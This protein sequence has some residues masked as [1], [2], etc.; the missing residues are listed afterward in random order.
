MDKYT[1]TLSPEI[2]SAIDKITEHLKTDEMESYLEE[3]TV[4]YSGIGDSSLYGGKHCGSDAEHQ[5]AQYIYD[6][7]K[8]IGIKAEMLPFESAR[9]QFN[10][11]SI[12]IEGEE[13]VKP[14]VCLSI[15]T[16]KD[17][18]TG[19]LIDAGKGYKAFYE[20]NDV[21][22]KIVLIETKEDFEDGTTE[23]MFQMMEAQR[24]GAAAVVIYTNENIYDE[25]TIR[26]TYGIFKPE[27]PVV[28]V[29]YK[30][31]KTLKNHA[32]EPVV[33]IADAEFDKDGGTSYEV[34][35]EIPGRTDERIIY[36]A[37]YDHFF[38]GIQDNV[39][40]AGTLLAIA[41]ALKKSGYTPNRTITFVFSGSHEIGNMESGA[42]DLLGV[43]ELLNNLKKEWK[44]KIFADINFEYTALKLN[45]LRSLVS[46]EMT[47]MYSDFLR[48][49]PKEVEVFSSVESEIQAEEYMLLTWCDACPF[50][51]EG[52]P[53][54]M[55]DAAYEQIYEN[56]SSYIGRDHTNKDDMSIYSK[57]THL[58]ASW[59]YGCL[60]V[61]LDNMPVLMPDFSV[62]AQVMRLADEEKTLLEKENLDYSAFEKE[63]KSFELLGDVAAKLLKNFN[64]K[65]KRDFSKD[66]KINKALLEIQKNLADASDGLTTMLPP[67]L[68][69]PHKTYI[70][71]AAV[72][73]R[74]LA[75]F[76]TSGFEKTYEQELKKL[77]LVGLDKKFS[78]EIII[79]VKGIALGKNATWNKNKCKNFFIAEDVSEKNWQAAREQNLDDVR[80]TLQEEAEFLSKANDLLTDV[81][82]ET[83]DMPDSDLMMKKIKEM[84]VLPHRKTGT[85]E[86]KKSAEYVEKTFRET[87]LEEVQTE[88]I[89]SVCMEW[90]K[91]SFEYGG[92]QI[93]CF[94]ANGTN[95]KAET[96]HF[97]SNIENAEIIYLNTGSAEDFENID[98]KG[99]IVLCD[100]FFKPFSLKDMMN[101]V[102]DSEI[103]DPL[104]KAEKPLKKYDIYTPNN[105]PYNYIAAMEKGAAGFI[106]I[107]H[108]FMDCHYY[109][110]DYRDIVSIA[111]Y[112]ELPAVWL[113]KEDGEA[114]KAEAGKNTVLGSL[115]VETVYEKKKARC[116]KGEIKGKTNNYILIHSHHDAVNKG[117]VQDASGMSVVFALAKFFREI[118]G[119]PLETGIMFA[120]TDSHYTDYEGHVGFI[121]N[122]QNENKNI[123]MD[124]AVEHIAKEMDLDDKNHTI[125][126]DEAETRIL[127]V[128]KN[129]DGLLELVRK[130]V[131]RFDLE[132]TVIFPVGKSGGDFTNDD[133]C[134]DA[135]DFNAA[136]IPVVSILAAPMYLFH[137]SDDIDKV[138]QPSLTKILKMY[139]YMILKRIN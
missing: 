36:S 82:F 57:E 108:N 49:M 103:Y 73:N 48:Y 139:A 110:E 101:W 37:H 12:I 44:G 117:A 66:A 60:G 3:F 113:S 95:R 70:E 58:T 61:Y 81:I 74:A 128:D 118:M 31:A 88:E 16:D 100:V 25:N 83:A 62:R 35:G 39:S 121:K 2:T 114:L 76:N 53:V 116:V 40:A 9:F 79:E 71:K 77:D 65:E 19:E 33:L 133:V 115:T 69:V 138:H 11:A 7:L 56:T 38:R 105:W 137:N 122:R 55:N 112:M 132:K 134:S 80:Q 67:M 63:L 93:D 15:G 26:A 21:K 50:V 135:Y 43:W 75:V 96:G 104:H 90:E 59:W 119:E 23:G 18:V 94:P 86:G 130:A 28:T 98:V 6:E 41:K 30:D 27:I 127:Y 22:G 102:E 14:Y 99:K 34:I 72:F 124:F 10:D 42:P 107:L 84:I 52:V 29:S 20:E 131:E 54:F 32:G 68:Q 46:Y 1:N 89:D 97:R 51:M 8:N 120:A 17:G 136:G 64:R 123:V 125:I 106:G 109:H 129:A 85:E 91:Y 5:G 13:A 87:G 47:D 24:Y 4:N 78:K 45:A 111:G 92:K 126:I